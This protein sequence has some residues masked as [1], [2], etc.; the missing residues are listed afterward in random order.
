MTFFRYPGGKA[1]LKGPIIS[2]IQEITEGQEIGAYLEPF[3]GGGS[4]CFALMDKHLFPH[5]RRV[6]INDWDFA[7]FCLWYSVIKDHKTLIKLVENFTPST[8][9]FYEFKDK[10][11]NVEFKKLSVADI[12]LMKLAIHQMS[13]S[14]LGVKA[15]G[16]IG[17]SKQASKY[18]VGCRWSPESMSKKIVK[19]HDLLIAN[20][21]TIHSSDFE[22]C[23][24][25]ANALLIYN[26]MVYLDPPY[27][28]KG[29]DLY[30]HG[31]DQKDH[32]RLCNRLK[33]AHYHWLLS[34]DDC[35]EIREMYS[36]AEIEEIN[37][38]YTIKTVRNKNELLIYKKVA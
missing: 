4:I 5:L 15:G 30:E 31:F 12:G 22:T 21:A 19:C 28:V 1:K 38:N 32:E 14:G 10:L 8:E 33:D 6:I 18:D 29:S 16:P 25:T 34:Y 13:Y 36:W 9:A 11:I 35:P 2:K 20:K 23:L 7:L 26:P 37:V 3:F 27:Y 17:G 24:N